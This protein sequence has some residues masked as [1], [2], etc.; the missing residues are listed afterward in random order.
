MAKQG[1]MCLLAS[2]A[3]AKDIAGQLQTHSTTIWSREKQQDLQQLEVGV[4]VTCEGARNE[5]KLRDMSTCSDGT[6]GKL[7][8]PQANVL[9]RCIFEAQAVLCILDYI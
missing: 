9:L 1:N 8:I 7:L 3:G 4:S 2:G 5:L 6:T